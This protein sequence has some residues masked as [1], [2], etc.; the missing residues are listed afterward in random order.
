MSG[1]CWQ[2]GILVLQGEEEV[3]ENGALLCADGFIIERFNLPCNLMV[4]Q[5]CMYNIQ[6]E[7]VEK[8]LETVQQIFD[9]LCF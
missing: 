1:R 3:K 2:E 5:A 9:G 8:A 6:G 7:D 4:A